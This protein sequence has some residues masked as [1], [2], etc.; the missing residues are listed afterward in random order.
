MTLPER[1]VQV[2]EQNNVMHV[3]LRTTNQS[4]DSRTMQLMATNLLFGCP[5]QVM[6]MLHSPW[7]WA[8]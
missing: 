7:T 1:L 6:P 8:G 4:P 2:L 5:I 3:Q